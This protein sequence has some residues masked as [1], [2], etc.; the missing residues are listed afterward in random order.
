MKVGDL[1]K[2]RIYGLCILLSKDIASYGGDWLVYTPR[3][4]GNKTRVR[5]SWLEAL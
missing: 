3:H 1:V 4:H 5:K 2:H